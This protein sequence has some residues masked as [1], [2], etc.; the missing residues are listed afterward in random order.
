MDKYF[1]SIFHVFLCLCIAGF[2]GSPLKADSISGHLE[3]YSQVNQTKHDNIDDS[4]SEHTHGH[5]HSENGEEHEHN[6]EHTQFGQLEIK[7]LAG[8]L[9]LRF[10]VNS[11]GPLLRPTIKNF[12]SNPHLL[13]IFRP[14]IS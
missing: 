1:S 13:R 5:K 7:I 3:L 11:I 10:R 12:I 4:G 8:S 6:H 2:G 9:D 14:P